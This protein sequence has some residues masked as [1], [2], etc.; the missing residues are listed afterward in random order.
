MDFPMPFQAILFDLDGTLIDSL[1]DIADSCNRALAAHG[2]PT[3][4]EDAYRYFVGD[5]VKS[6]LLRVLPPEARREPFL[7]QCMD[8]YVADYARGWNIKTRPYAGIPQLLDSASARGMRLAVLSN[9]PHPFTVQCV[10]AFLAGYRFDMVMG[11]TPQFP[12]KPDPQ[13]AV[14]IARTMNIAP[15]QFLYLGDTATDMQTAVAAGMVPLGA[16]WGF[17]KADELLA[18]GAKALLESPADLL[19]FLGRGAST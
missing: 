14:H 9:K 15:A 10:E 6:L 1:A 19:N 12:H 8:A 2:Y 13:G 5:G 4:P 16:L 7:S 18:A 17:R 3:H 11:A